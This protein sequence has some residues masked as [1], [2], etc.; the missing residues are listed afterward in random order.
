MATFTY[1]TS[2]D[3]DAALAWC[4]KEQQEANA[5]AAPKD[6]A[7]LFTALVADRLGGLCR[8]HCAATDAQPDALKAKIDTADAATLAKVAAVLGSA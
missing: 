8:D 1:T 5:D 2:E 7:A 6:E 3:E 4:L